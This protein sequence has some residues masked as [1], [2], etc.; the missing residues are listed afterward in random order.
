V[1]GEVVVLQEE[2]EKPEL[3]LDERELL[4][5]WEEEVEMEEAVEKGDSEREGMISLSREGLVSC[6]IM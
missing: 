1:V 5:E 2:R 4:R 6:A 3:E